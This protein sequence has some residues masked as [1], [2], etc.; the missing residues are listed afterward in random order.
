MVGGVVRQRRGRSF[1]IVFLSVTL[2][3]KLFSV[4]VKAGL[5]KN[6]DAYFLN[7]TSALVCSYCNYYVHRT[8]VQ[9]DCPK[10]HLFCAGCFDN[11]STGAGKSEVI[12]R[13]LKYK[14]FGCNAAVSGSGVFHKACR[15]SDVGVDLSWVNEELDRQDVAC[16]RQQVGC[17]W[18]GTYQD[19]SV[20]R[21]QCEWLNIENCET[22][23]K[24]Y[25]SS[26]KKNHVKT[27]PCLDEF[28]CLC[29]GVKVSSSTLES[30]YL[31]DCKGEF[32]AKACDQV[33]PAGWSEYLRPELNK[34]IIN[35]RSQRTGIV[36]PAVGLNK[37]GSVCPR[38]KKRV[39]VFGK[40]T[41]L[42]S[43]E[44]CQQCLSNT[45]AC[46]LVD[47]AAD[48]HAQQALKLQQ[49]LAYF[50]NSEMEASDSEFRQAHGAWFWFIDAKNSEARV[51]PALESHG[52]T[53]VLRMDPAKGSN[54]AKLTVKSLGESSLRNHA[55]RLRLMIVSA[56]KN[57]TS[58]GENC[59][60]VS[61]TGP[62]FDKWVLGGAT[63]DQSIDIPDR[64][65]MI[66][67]L[68]GVGNIEATPRLDK[69]KLI[70]IHWDI[71][72]VS[73][74]FRDVANPSTEDSALLLESPPV[75]CNDQAHYLSFHRKEDWIGFSMD[76]DT[77]P[78]W[79]SDSSKAYIV[80][81]QYSD[82]IWSFV[83][84][85][86]RQSGGAL[87]EKA[88]H[89][90]KIRDYLRIASNDHLSVTVQPIRNEVTVKNKH[91]VWIPDT[92]E[93][94]LQHTVNQ[95]TIQGH[96]RL[97]S[98]NI[99]LK[100]YMFR[101]SVVIGNYGRSLTGTS[102]SWFDDNSQEKPMLIMARL[103]QYIASSKRPPLP[104]NVLL[105]PSP[106]S[107]I[108]WDVYQ[109]ST[110]SKDIEVHFQLSGIHATTVNDE[111]WEELS[112]DVEGMGLDH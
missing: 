95:P 55:R 89:W 52:V 16:P 25:F 26:D 31:F 101:G 8:F 88:I 17:G 77:A 86:G 15:P 23:K 65:L 85:P 66:I 96:A 51:T 24:S 67:P 99:W 61:L 81:I 33:H 12:D 69:K 102:L 79:Q 41:D 111:Q 105:K 56:D 19:L 10:Q 73:R 40:S 87:V 110:L 109:A 4:D 64:S 108:R 18:E 59:Y 30:H 104:Q 1:W 93:N 75:V 72:N 106:N 63:D 68:T 21:S 84:Q 14:C 32:S 62:Q 48:Q 35:K 39:P 107:F 100:G 13:K 83:F 90:L 54:T 47:S 91:V 42:A 80:S 29:C 6:H 7:P 78:P 94:L 45:G 50:G 57:E 98:A 74:Y 38:C 2:L 27:H 34:K 9:M 92:K 76:T 5:D 112:A 82:Q 58:H 3:I 49:L 97:V 103:R 70:T 46:V 22:C 36:I 11:W 20:H 44:R 71:D 60:W 53:F 37:A 43:L 28:S